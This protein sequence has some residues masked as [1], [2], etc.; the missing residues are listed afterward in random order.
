MLV[1]DLCVAAYAVDRLAP[2]WYSDV[3]R[4][5]GGRVE[6]ATVLVADVGDRVVGTVTLMESP[7]GPLQEV[8]QENE[9]EFRMLAVD[10]VAQGRGVG[11][12]LVRA[13]LS[14]ASSLGRR[15]LVCCSRDRM[16]AAHRLYDRL[17]F[18]R[19]PARDWSPQEGIVLLGFV[20]RLAD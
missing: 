15:A 9:A 3:L 18:T 14:R 6:A 17:G 2:S 19:D 8:A 13:C 5:V 1:G 11:E 16:A 12:A 20:R 4:D 7:G 10:P